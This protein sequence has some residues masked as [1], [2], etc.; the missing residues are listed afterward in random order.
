MAQ[1]LR[2]GVDSASVC[3]EGFCK[4]VP[5]LLQQ[6]LTLLRRRS[7]PGSHQHPGHAGEQQPQ[8]RQFFFSR[9]AGNKWQQPLTIRFLRRFDSFPHRQRLPREFRPQ[10]SENTTHSWRGRVP[11]AQ[12]A[13]DDG[14][15]SVSFGRGLRNFQHALSHLVECPGYGLDEQVVLALKM[16]VEAPFGQAH[17]FHQ[18]PDAAGVPAVLAERTSGYGKYIL[19]VLGFVFGRV[20]HPARIEYVRTLRC[21]ADEKGCS[22][23]ELHLRFASPPFPLNRA[24]GTGD[25]RCFEDRL[26][27][28][29][30]DPSR[31]GGAGNRRSVQGAVE[32]HQ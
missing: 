10:C 2:R 14:L 24:T 26:R 6:L 20:S 4:E 5:R 31:L 12:V 22:K 29:A 27:H 19:V 16:P 9:L 1:P 15:E 25:P 11:R 13:F 17:L 7:Q 3:R 30:C 28:G 8:L 23:R 18:R 21:Q 32:Q